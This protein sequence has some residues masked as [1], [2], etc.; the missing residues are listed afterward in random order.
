[1]REGR[2]ETYKGHI[3]KDQEVSFYNSNTRFF[4]SL[5]KIIERKF[6]ML[7]VHS[8]NTI[9]DQ[10]SGYN[11]VYYMYMYNVKAP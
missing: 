11:M 9:E 6:H 3:Y 4:A 2:I 8:M 7:L 10:D 5:H 1:M